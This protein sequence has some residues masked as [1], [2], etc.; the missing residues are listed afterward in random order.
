MLAYLLLPDAVRDMAKYHVSEAPDLANNP[1]A[2]A[3]YNMKMFRAQ[4]NY[5]IVIFSTMLFM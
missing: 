3:V 2:E 4:R 1:M 5:Y